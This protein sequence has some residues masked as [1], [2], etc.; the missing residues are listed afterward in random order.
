MQSLDR[1]FAGAGA[2][3]TLIFIVGMVVIW[4]APETKG[5]PLPA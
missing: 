5:K 2:I 1:G 3:I 4:I